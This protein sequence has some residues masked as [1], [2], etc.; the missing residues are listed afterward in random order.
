MQNILRGSAQKSIFLF[1][2]LL[3]VWW[4]PY[5]F[6]VQPSIAMSYVVGYN[7]QAAVIIFLLCA[8]TFAILTQGILS[9]LFDDS[10]QNEPVTDL[11][12]ALVLAGLFCFIRHHHAQPPKSESSYAINRLQML[13]SGGIPYRDFEFIYGPLHLYVPLAAAKLFGSSIVH[14]YYIWWY[15]QWFVGV[16]MTWTLVKLLPF[17][18]SRRRWIFAGSIAFQLMSIINEGTAYTPVRIIGEAFSVV[19]ICAVWRRTRSPWLLLLASSLAIFLGFGIS[20]EQGLALGIGL[21]AW[22]I[23]KI[24]FERTWTSGALAGGMILILASILLFFL[25][26][27]VLKEFHDFSNG[28]YSFPLLPSI[29]IAVV[30][31][32]YLVAACSGV[33]ALRARDLDGPVI[34]MLLCGF[35]ALPGAFGRCDLGHLQFASAAFYL[36]IAEIEAQ[37]NLRRVWSPLFLFYLVL[38]PYAGNFLGLVLP[39][40]RKHGDTAAI[41]EQVK[42]PPVPRM[43][44]R[45][46]LLAP[47]P[48]IYSSPVIEPQYDLT[49]NEDCLR[50]GYFA[51]LID[52]LTPEGIQHKI[53]EITSEPRRPI[54]LP[55]L[56]IEKAFYDWTPEKD[57]SPLLILEGGFYLPPPK[58]RPLDYLPIAKAIEMNYTPGPPLEGG[59]RVWQPNPARH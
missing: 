49:P 35:A 58:N 18:L 29:P 39:K 1:V 41:A 4:L 54:L 45:P 53:A 23:L 44:S 32:A 14:G 8:A 2:A 37:P 46:V 17:N 40:L 36:G 22:L 20:P 31:F 25:R 50:T 7:N 13:V 16:I 48:V 38:L 28:A 6:A 55:D 27:G 21:I 15:L 24:W 56:P 42:S 47:C 11:L 59:Y 33:R 12:V 9:K 10:D 26:M 51:G 30:L 52:V 3:F 43:E 57:I 19:V 34:P 5:F